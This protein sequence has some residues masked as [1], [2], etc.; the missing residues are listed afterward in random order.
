MTV[1]YS[2]VTVP[3]MLVYT[4]S[5]KTLVN[6]SMPEAYQE[7]HSNKVLLCNFDYLYTV[8]HCPYEVLTSLSCFNIP[9]HLYIRRANK[10]FIKAF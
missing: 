3:F 2:D 5:H 1:V 9:W 8:V 6:F 4:E 10:G 7:C